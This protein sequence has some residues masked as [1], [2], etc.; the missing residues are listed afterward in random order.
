MLAP[1][2]PL[3]TMGFLVLLI[4]SSRLSASFHNHNLLN[5]N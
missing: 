4:D 5:K 2:R 3:C 1:I